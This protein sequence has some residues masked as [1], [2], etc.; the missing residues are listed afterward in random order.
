[1]DSMKSVERFFLG[2]QNRPN[3]D[4]VE[5]LP[6]TVPPLELWTVIDVT[7][8][9]IS[10]GNR[11]ILHLDAQQRSP[12]IGWCNL[13]ADLKSEIASKR[14]L[15]TISS[16]CWTKLI[17][18][19]ILVLPKELLKN[20]YCCPFFFISGFKIFFPN[21]LVASEY[22][23]QPKDRLLVCLLVCF[24]PPRSLFQ[25]SSH[26]SKRTQKKRRKK[27]K[28]RRNTQRWNWF[29]SNIKGSLIFIFDDICHGNITIQLITQIGQFGL[30]FGWIKSSG[31]RFDR[32]GN[33]T[34]FK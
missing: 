16:W 24:L 29:L 7:N 34:H 5:N 2:T 32:I 22:Q 11:T 6:P 31:K 10:S 26:R 9:K 13:Q 1:M 25:L 14:N 23:T 4:R 28:E 20:Y 27:K 8:E 17:P 33:T 15:L 3:C 12:P 21:A 19:S 18:H 30:D